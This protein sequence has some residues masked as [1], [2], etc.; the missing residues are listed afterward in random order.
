M[1]DDLAAG[2]EEVGHRKRWFAKVFPV[3]RPALVYDIT[4]AGHHFSAFRAGNV[5]DRAIGMAAKRS[6]GVMG[7]PAKRI[8]DLIGRGNVLG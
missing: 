4:I 5:S 1:V 7:R 2:G 6:A 8:V 3:V